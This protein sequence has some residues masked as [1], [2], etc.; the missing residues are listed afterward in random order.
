M[1]KILLTIFM[2]FTVITVDA[3]I[4][5]NVNNIKIENVKVNVKESIGYNEELK[6]NYSI[7]P[8]DAKN[9][10]LDWKIEGLKKGITVDFANGKTTN[11]AE[12]I[13][14]LKV[15]NTLDK[16][17]VLTLKAVQNNKVISTTKLNVENKNITVERVNKELETLINNLDEKLNKENYEENKEDIEKINE[18]LKNNSEVKLS[19][20]LQSK[21]ENVKEN[22]NNYKE[23]NKA[24]VIG[25]SAG[26]V[27][28]F[29]GL[30]YWIF[31]REE[32]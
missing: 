12:G 32:K 4:K 22:V 29:S 2:L 23:N 8:R 31:K 1:K 25:V 21:Y 24:F 11:E 5:G 27:V 9:L 28:V 14:T 10:K 17:V 13:I 15:N 16:T 26:L 19:D 18:L 7:N 30:L 3:S 20:E 6:V